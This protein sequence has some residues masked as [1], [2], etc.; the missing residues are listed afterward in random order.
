MSEI[1][2]R[3]EHEKNEP[4]PPPVLNSCRFHTNLYRLKHEIG[5]VIC[6]TGSSVRNCAASEN[7][8]APGFDAVN[9][10]YSIRPTLG[11]LLLQT[12]IALNVHALA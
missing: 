10:F 8:A 12:E 4:Q 3:S 6:I 11:Q 5:A 9:L 2:V 7:D 1:G